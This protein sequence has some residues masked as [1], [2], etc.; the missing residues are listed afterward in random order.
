MRALLLRHPAVPRRRRG[1]HLARAPA[2]RLLRRRGKR[3]EAHPRDG[4]R[5][6]E[7]ERLLCEAGP[8]D[9]VGVAALAVALE[10]VAGDACAEQEQVVEVR[11]APLRA[12]AAN[13]VDALPRCALDLRD[14][15][16][17]EEVRLAESGAPAVRFGRGHQYA[18]STLKL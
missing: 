12:E 15:V 5:D 16:A 1:A 9:D 14:R 13:V 10:R 4:Y 11:H 8:E 2:E 18:L 3:A 17:V 7:R 6:L